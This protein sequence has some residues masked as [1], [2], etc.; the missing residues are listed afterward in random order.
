MTAY[1]HVDDADA[2]ADRGAVD[3]RRHVGATERRTRAHIVKKTI[4]VTMWIS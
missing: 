2:V 1:C 4:A 3:D